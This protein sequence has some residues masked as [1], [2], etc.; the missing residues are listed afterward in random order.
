VD[1][2]H[3]A[4]VAMKTAVCLALALFGSIGVAD[5]ATARGLGPRPGPQGKNGFSEVELK[6]HGKRARSHHTVVVQLS[7]PQSAPHPT[8]PDGTPGHHAI[9][10][11]FPHTRVHRF[12]MQDGDGRRHRMVLTD[13]EGHH[14]LS[15]TV[16]EECVTA[17][18]KA[19]HYTVTLHHDGSGTPSDVNTV[20]IQPQI[21]PVDVAGLSSLTGGE[22]TPRAAAEPSIRAAD[23]YDAQCY[24]SRPDYICCSH[25]DTWGLQASNGFY[26]TVDNVWNR[27]GRFPY[28]AGTFA[29]FLST[30]EQDTDPFGHTGSLTDAVK[31]EVFTCSLRGGTGPQFPR[32]TIFL[33]APFFSFP[34]LGPWNRPTGGFF[35][36]WDASE[37][38]AYTGA[39][40]PG[41]GKDISCQLDERTDE[42]RCAGPSDVAGTGGPFGCAQPL[43]LTHYDDGR[44]SLSATMLRSSWCYEETSDLSG[45]AS[46]IVENQASFLSLYD[47]DSTRP[48]AEL[49]D[50]AFFTVQHDRTILIVTGSCSHC[51]LKGAQ[52]ANYNLAGANLSGA[53][54]SGAHL[55][56]AVLSFAYM[57]D[58]NLA[59]ADLTGAHLNNVDFYQVSKRPSLNGATLYQTK[60]ANANLIGIDLSNA[61]LEGADFSGAQMLGA[62]LTGITHVTGPANG[63]VSFVK[64]LLAG[65]SFFNSTF[66]GGDFT[67]AIFSTKSGSVD[68]LVRNSPTTTV[69]QPYNFGATVRP[70]STTRAT[71]CPDTTS[72]PCATDAQWVAQNPPIY[73]GYNS[74]EDW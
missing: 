67:N 37:G 49:P 46:Y 50:T 74:P 6:A 9:P 56:G 69:T 68:L 66:D 53:D 29:R 32:G 21:D 28:G 35:Y 61:H 7:H 70:L 59:G 13:A 2:P 40:V 52:L 41:K 36:T 18:I 15:V 31:F 73:Q 11:E 20:F 14:V 4:G 16:G 8:N 12:C 26:V 38:D 44:I 54:L 34:W 51:N 25:V 63:Q 45:A 27:T 64:A 57:P 71:V 39:L 23:G 33:S 55:E 62:L 43:H 72:G 30:Y 58:A 3:A 5:T 65:V 19:G 47:G 42:T 24:S 1:P 10:Y 17:T 22:P 48:P 60:F